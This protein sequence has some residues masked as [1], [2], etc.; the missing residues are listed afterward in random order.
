MILYCHGFRSSPFSFKAQ[1]LSARLAQLGRAHE[2]C[3]PQLDVSP[4]RAIA[5]LSEIIQN[6]NQPIYLIGSSLGGFYAT[7]LLE[8]FSRASAKN[9]TCGQ[10][11]SISAVLLNPAVNPQRDLAQHL[12]TQTVYHSNE[13]VT[14]KAEHIAEL[15]AL[16]TSRIQQPKDYFLIATTGDEVLDY[17]EAQALYAGAQQKIIQGSDHGISEFADY[18]DDVIAFCTQGSL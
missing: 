1:I 3:C 5:Q 11:L 12:G 14:V 17:R 7:Y 4:R 13:S 6:A 15:Q 10:N 8:Q 2:W 9:I 18:V 16:H